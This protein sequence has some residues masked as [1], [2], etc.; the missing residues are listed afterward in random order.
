MIVDPDQVPD[1]IIPL[2]NETFEILETLVDA[3]LIVPPMKALP[4]I[5]IPPLT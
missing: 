3:T 2:V 5:P 1:V 4:V